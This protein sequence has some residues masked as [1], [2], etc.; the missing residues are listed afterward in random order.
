[1][2]QIDEVAGAA[3]NI[4]EQCPLAEMLAHKMREN[5]VDLTRRWL[6][7]IVARVQVDP[8][9][10]FP[11]EELLNHVPLLIHGIAEFIEHP[12]SV[13]LT[14]VPV[15]AK[16]RELGE[17]RF[18]QRFDEYEVLKEY[19]IFGG[20]L[21]AFL[22][23]T[24]DEIDEPCSRSQ[25]LACAQRLFLA[26]TLIQQATLTQYL[27]LAR[28]DLREREN[29]LR[30]FNTMVSHELKNRLGAITGAAAVLEL[31]TLSGDERA[32]LTGVVARNVFGMQGVLDNLIELSRVDADFRQQRH[33][34]LPKA[35]MEARRQ[36]RDAASARNV[37]VRISGDLPEVEVNAAAVEL[38][39]T[40]LVAN[41]IKYSD[42]SKSD[43]WVEISVRTG[44]R[45]SA[46][47]NEEG[48]IIVEVR[49][50]GIGVPQ[51][52]RARLFERFFRAHD[53]TASKIGGTG[54]GLSIVRNTA[55]SFG[56]TAW[57]DHLD[58]GTV[59]SFTLPARRAS[60]T[61]AVDASGDVTA[62][63]S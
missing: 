62:A 20:I 25:L 53:D 21:F 32:R 27:T 28:Q 31:P 51:D 17:L 34:T 13:I 12:E 26:V 2:S 48:V 45:D 42:T 11:T 59:F 49:D 33:V 61:A 44:P 57:A 3:V 35:A 43:R 60:D 37:D 23:R 52:K 46:A 7:R 38:C 18:E 47:S 9:R 40:N 24:V 10:V 63:E 16:A 39:L 58:N 41:G 19:E 6:D 14:D 29:R 4:A 8:Y 54:L 56:G 30:G 55:E 15:I 36:L 50:N 5:S 1:M 22:A